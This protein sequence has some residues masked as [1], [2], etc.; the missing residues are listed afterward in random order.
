MQLSGFLIIITDE[1]FRC[2]YLS[3]QDQAN[4]ILLTD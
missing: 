2:L 3:G 1:F 4:L